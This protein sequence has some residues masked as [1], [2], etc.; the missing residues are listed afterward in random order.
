MKIVV[1]FIILSSYLFSVDIDKKTNNFSLVEHSYYFLDKEN[2]K[3]ITTLEDK[4]FVKSSKN[5]LSFGFSNDNLWIKLKL[6]NNTDKSFEKVLEYSSFLTERIE[7]YYDSRVDI[8]GMHYLKNRETTNPYIFLQFKPYEEKVIYIKSNCDTATLIA[9]LTLWNETEFFNHDF[10]H[11]TILITL[12]FGIVVLLLYN[13]MLLIFTKDKA[14]L[15]YNLYLVTI[16]IIQGNYNGITALYLQSQELTIF[17]SNTMI[18]VIGLMGYFITQFTRVFLNT[19]QFGT[20]DKVIDIYAKVLPII[21][22]TAIY[23][24]LFDLTLIITFLPLVFLVI[25]TAFYALLKGV[26]QAKYYVLGWSVV[27]L[28]LVAINIRSLGFYDIMTYFPYINETAY[29]FEAFLFSIALAHKIKITNKE[30]EQTNKLLLEYEQK[31]Q[32]RLKVL[33]DEKTKDL[34]KSLEEK[35]VLYNELNHRVKNNLQM[36]LSLLDLQIDS[37]SSKEVNKE[38]YSIRNR[39]SSISNLYE[40]MYLNSENLNLDTK[41]YFTAIIDNIKR[42]NDKVI[43]INLIVKYDFNM[44]EIMYGGIILNELLT[45]IYKYAYKEEG[46]VNIII[47]KKDERIYF[48]VEDYGVGSNSTKESLG[49]TIVKN[50]VQKQFLGNISFKNEDGF[51]VYMDWEEKV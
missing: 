46:K 34:K 1:F 7:F 12:M 15:F 19:A 25:A 50:L 51:K 9:K 13:T 33:V 23:N 17:L 22:L 48:V 44:K 18:V 37:V 42:L 49:M 32:E 39:I 2:L 3:N 47:Y 16:L 35:A 41:S 28:A 31:E 27:L 40:L 30:K 21:S 45:N 14:Y 43:D 8:G 24:W 36:I 26:R 4:D 10:K 11:K 20:I 5:T 6:K 38:L 29:L